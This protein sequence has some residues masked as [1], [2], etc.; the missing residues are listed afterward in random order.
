M[1]RAATH[2]FGLMTS[3]RLVMEAGETHLDM[4]AKPN[5]GG[6]GVRQREKERR[7]RKKKMVLG[8]GG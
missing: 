2:K 8:I 4:L 5:Q 6:E 1:T 7:G 3:G